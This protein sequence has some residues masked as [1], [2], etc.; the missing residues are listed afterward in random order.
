MSRLERAQRLAIFLAVGSGV[1]GFLASIG[2]YLLPIRAAGAAWLLHPA[3]LALSLAGGYATV[4]R[5]QE[6]D[7]RRWEILEEP[8]LTSGEREYAHKEAERQR[9][10]AA[11]AFF[12]APVFVGFWMT[13]QFA[14]EG[15][16]SLAHFFPIPTLLGYVLGLVLA[17]LQARRPG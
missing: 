6:I 12:A 8:L 14:V 4:L 5:G 1:L 13:S 15:E 9:R 3:L 2:L 10:V 7:R 11:T 17:H 16:I